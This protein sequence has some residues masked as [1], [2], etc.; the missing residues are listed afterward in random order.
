MRH[1]RSLAP[2]PLRRQLFVVAAV[3]LGSLLATSARGL[4]EYALPSIVATTPMTDLH[5]PLSAD[6]R[7]R[8]LIHLRAISQRAAVLGLSAVLL[9]GCGA[10]GV[11]I[12]ATAAAELCAEFDTSGSDRNAL[13]LNANVAGKIVAELPA[14]TWLKVR[15]FDGGIATVFDGLAPSSRRAFLRAVMRKLKPGAARPGSHI[16]LA[17]ADMAAEARS[18]NGPFVGMIFSDF[19]DTDLTVAKVKAMRASAEELA[20]NPRVRSVI[21]VGEDYRASNVVEKALA[22]LAGRKLVRVDAE[23]LDPR[24]VAGVLR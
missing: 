21:V 6:R 3:H 16:D 22:P 15:R 9:G 7:G 11:F 13:P 4:R 2:P 5:K 10:H 18:G 14:G 20:R 19:L 1:L 17:L 23:R 8:P 24:S 12:K